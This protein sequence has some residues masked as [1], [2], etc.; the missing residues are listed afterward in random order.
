MTKFQQLLIQGSE[1]QILFF[2]YFDK[3]LKIPTPK[4][5][6][7]TLPPHLDGGGALHHKPGMVPGVEG[8]AGG[9]GHSTGPRPPCPSSG[10]P[11]PS[12]G[13]ADHPRPQ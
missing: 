8:K 2:V 10:C 1:K 12:S 13:T 7:I 9:A 4:Q 5:L 3:F 11:H 6:E